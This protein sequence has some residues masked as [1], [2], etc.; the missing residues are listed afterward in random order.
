VV[1]DR[2]G[3]CDGFLRWNSSVAQPF[4]LLHLTPYR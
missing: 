2:E 3:F 1:E 4:F